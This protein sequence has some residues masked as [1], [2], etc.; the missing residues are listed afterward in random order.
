VLYDGSQEPEEIFFRALLFKMF[1]RIETWEALARARGAASWRTFS[2]EAYAAVLYG[3]IE[4]GERIYSAAYIMPSPAFGSPRKHRNHLRLLEHMMADG[5]PGRIARAG[6]LR[7]VF[8]ILRGYPSLG[9]FLAFQFTIDLNYSGLTDFSEMDFVV[10]GPG[11]RDGIRKCFSDTA[12][13]D[14]A[15]IIRVMA[16]RAEIEFARL[17]LNF[18]NLWGRRLQL[19]DCQNLFCEV[20]KYARVAHPEIRGESGRT[21]IKQKFSPHSK[22]IPQWYPPKWGLSLPPLGAQKSETIP[23]PAPSTRGHLLGRTKSRKAS[24]ATKEVLA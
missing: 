17:G 8:E 4:S 1:N 2:F 7:E 22:P 20:S 14:E 15:E 19:V 21:R 16:E 12:G 11:A 18:E 5:A 13:L 9:G 23:Q 24:V 10:A 6:S 3:L